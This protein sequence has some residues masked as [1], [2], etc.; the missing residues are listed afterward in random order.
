MAP[1]S[2]TSGSAYQVATG[3]FN[4]DPEWVS[5]LKS[6]SNAYKSPAGFTSWREQAAVICLRAYLATKWEDLARRWG[7]SPDD[8]VLSHPSVPGR[9][10]R[11]WDCLA[12][13]MAID[14]KAPLRFISDEL[15]RAMLATRVPELDEIPKAALPSV[16]LAVPDRAVPCIG[17]DWVTLIGCLPKSVI[18]WD[19]EDG[20]QPSA[21]LFFTTRAGKFIYFV[22]YWSTVAHRQEVR[23]SLDADEGLRESTAKVFDDVRTL[24]LGARLVMA[25][26]P[27]LVT[28][29]LL[30]SAP[31]VGFGRN[32]NDAPG[33]RTAVWIGK[34]YRRQRQSKARRRG[35][36]VGFAVSPH[37][38][39]G[40]WH[41]VRHGVGRKE[42]RLDWYEPVW[43][44]SGRALAS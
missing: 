15:C 3:S 33:P 21:N 8:V 5:L 23:E 19:K 24:A 7:H 38:R 6:Y 25:H 31:G 4:G 41:T 16:I 20:E 43:V 26:K 11:L 44:D 2:L 18:A 32:R 40:H 17:E 27:D 35:E 30:P 10:V 14:Q 13:A 9:D 22:C 34:D 42:S 37:W 12:S 29:E 36:P 28:E 1:V 39:S